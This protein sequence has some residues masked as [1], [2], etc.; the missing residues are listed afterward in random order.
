MT[1]KFFAGVAAAALSSVLTATPTLTR[2]LPCGP[3]QVSEIRPEADSAAIDLS[4][5][6]VVTQAVIGGQ[7]VNAVLDTGASHTVVD[8]ELAEKLGISEGDTFAVGGVVAKA[9]GR[10]ASKVSV[11]IGPFI[12]NADPIIM[13]LSNAGLHGGIIVGRDFFDSNIVEFDF[14][15]NRIRAVQP[16]LLGT[17]SRPIDLKATPTRLLSIPLQAANGNIQANLD[18]GSQIALIVDPSML[19]SLGVL[20]VTSDWVMGDVSGLHVVGSTTVTR[21]GLAGA[22]LPPVPALVQ[23]RDTG[24][25]VTIGLPIIRR[26]SLVLDMGGRRL[27]MTPTERLNDAFRRDRSGAALDP[28]GERLAV[29][30][31]AKNSPA[32]AAGMRVG[33]QII[34]VDG[35]RVTQVNAA[36][37]SRLANGE[38][39]ETLSLLTDKGVRHQLILTDYF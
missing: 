7:T 28:Q 34:E 17:R 32:E 11:T 35:E 26:F 33:D 12:Y 38:S 13:D 10:K 18:L 22:D 25:G 3:A 31:V 5:G 20:A 14:T 6:S 21:V 30:H 19:E 9:T 16:Q 29:A 23:P 1:R 4:S 24:R 39:R 27:W 36:T 2:A 8:S 37:L 15:A